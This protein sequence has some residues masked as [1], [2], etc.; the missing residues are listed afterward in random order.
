MSI[1]LVSAS[2]WTSNGSGRTKYQ[3]ATD[4]NYEY[5]LGYTRVRVEPRTPPRCFDARFGCCVRCG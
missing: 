3:I 2:P 5:R 1:R 4:Y